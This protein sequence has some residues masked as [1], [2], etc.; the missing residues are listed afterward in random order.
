MEKHIEWWNNYKW[1]V[2][3]QLTFNYFGNRYYESLTDEEIKHIW[4]NEVT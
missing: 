3:Q 2:H 1:L 4:K